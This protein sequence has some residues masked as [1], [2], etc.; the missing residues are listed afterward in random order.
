MKILEL[1]MRNY[2]SLR[3]VKVELGDYAVFIGE[4]GSGKTNIAE[5]LYLFFNDFSF[6][7]GEASPMLQETLSWYGEQTAHPIDFI[8]E[9]EL[10]SEEWQE[11]F[12]GEVLAKIIEKCGE[13]YRRLTLHRQVAKPG[14]PWKTK[15]IKVA[16]I[17]LVKDDTPISLEELSKSLG[18]E[19]RKP[20]I[21]PAKAYLFDPN[22]DQANLIG[23]R[24]IVF[25]DKAYHMDNYVD[26]LVRRGQV[27]FEKLAGVD[28]KD[29]VA[30]SGLTLIGAPP[31]KQ[32][33][34]T[35][36]TSLVTAEGFQQIQNKIAETVKGRF[37]L[38]P[39]SRNEKV[40]PGTR[41]SFVDQET[42]IKPLTNL[43]TTD[44]R[45]YHKMRTVIERLLSPKRVETVPELVIWEGNFRFL[46][47]MIGGGEQEIIGLMW[48]IY[49]ADGAIV[50]IEEPEA[51]LHYNLS[52][53]LFK[54]LKEESHERQILI[55]THCEQFT[56]R[57][58]Y[59]SNWVVE[60]SNA[61]TDIRQCESLKDLSDAF[62]FMGAQ[63]IDRGFPNKV[64]FVAGE[65]EQDVLP[66]WAERMEL[67]I[68]DVKIEPLAGER[69]Q[70]KVKVIQDYTKDT[71]TSV[72]LMVDHHASD[73]VKQALPEE[74]RL[75]LEGTIEDC[76][77]VGILLD[78]LND[79]YGTELT[80]EQID[81]K[82]P[83]VR[84]IQRILKEKLNIP[85][86]KTFWKPPVGREVAKRMSREDI[87][88]NI[89][90]FMEKILD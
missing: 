43:P 19:I 59:S 50:A 36:Q 85:H 7:G 37:L 54:L 16:D 83:R 20:A 81:P 5:A 31:T 11:V 44:W 88:Q 55:F 29:W 32:E 70:R 89:R 46:V 53:E 71:Q 6:I 65:T 79:L 26:E 39:A 23:S 35:G 15:H 63:A 22:A 47:K 13:D 45:M 2:K 8:L 77:P 69:D 68:D 61:E 73:K 57:R 48:R 52:R 9:L 42:I 17:F 38:I 90:E 66:I 75:I 4:N 1:T 67:I 76:Y 84:E 21:K 56:D 27:P 60:K 12:P 74:H 51:H 30:Q 80:E 24:L 78:V 25:D 33:L 3:E 28:Y 72:F 87:P 82:K 34:E 10:T 40:T 14:E 62:G 58:E 41:E 18:K 64:L 86:S 49:S